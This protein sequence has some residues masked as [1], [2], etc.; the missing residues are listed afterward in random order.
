MTKTALTALFAASAVA[1]IVTCAVVCNSAHKTAKS[2]PPSTLPP[3]PTTPPGARGASSL[4]YQRLFVWQSG[5]W[6]LV[7]SGWVADVTPQ[8]FLQYLAEEFPPTYAV[9]QVWDGASWHV[10]RNF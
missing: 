1:G 9:L 7:T 10:E 5:A 6:Q 3:V 4:S 2:L 8:S